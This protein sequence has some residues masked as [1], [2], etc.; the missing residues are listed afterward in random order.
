MG[1]IGSNTI[2]AIATRSSISTLRARRV[3]VE[4]AHAAKPLRIAYC[5]VTR[6]GPAPSARRPNGAAGG[7]LQPL[8]DGGR[9]HV[10]GHPPV[11]IVH[12]PHE[13]INYLGGNWPPDGARV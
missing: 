6:S 8:A 2:R 4:G 11:G 9:V 3:T 7:S 13:G 10:H 12:V 1:R 5:A